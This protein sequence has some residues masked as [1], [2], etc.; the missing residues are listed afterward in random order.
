MN[1]QKLK[2]NL[3]LLLAA[4]VWGISFIAQSKGVELISPVAFIGIR[5]MLGALVLVPVILVIDFGKKK[6]GI[7]PQGWTKELFL[8]GTI[9]GILLFIA[10]ILQTA[11]MIYTSPGKSGFITALYMVIVPFFSFFA[12]KK[13]SG[14][15]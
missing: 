15:K 5:T 9:C 1:K 10:T 2:G 8:A 7:V 3:L 13:P 6:K 4:F 11:G 12:G 14:R